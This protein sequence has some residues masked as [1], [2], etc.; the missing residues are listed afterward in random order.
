MIEEKGFTLIELMIVVAI[1]GVLAGIAYPSYQ[2]SVLK[3]RRRDAEGVLLGFANA[4]ERYYTETNSYCD[5]G[6]T[7][8]ASSCGTSTKDTGSPSIFSIKSP[9][10]GSD[11]YYD[12]TISAVSDNSYTIRATPFGGQSN[13]S[14]GNLEL[15]HT[16][17][18]TPATSGCW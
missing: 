6:G 1:I 17:V 13:D 16:G 12:L 4:M 9:L 10:D 14:C 3:S 18:K 15:T 2:D 11:K 7:G 8:G 5:A